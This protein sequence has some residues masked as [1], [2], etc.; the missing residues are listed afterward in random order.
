M[1]RR[2]FLTRKKNTNGQQVLKYGICPVCKREDILTTH[3]IKKRAVFGENEYVGIICR[4]CHDD[5]DRLVKVFENQILTRFEYCYKQIWV[6]YTRQGSISHRK[7]KALAKNQFLKINSKVFYGKKSRDYRKKEV[8]CNGSSK[9]KL[10]EFTNEQLAKYRSSKCPVCF[11]STKLTIHHIKKRSVFGHNNDVGFPC[12]DC[13]D[14]I[15]ES[16]KYLEAEI[17]KKFEPCYEKI[18]QLYCQNGYISED[19]VRKMAKKQLLKVK[20]NLTGNDK[21]H[22]R[23]FNK[24]KINEAEYIL[25]NFQQEKTSVFI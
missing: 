1:S 3:H 18:W 24:R 12:R 4:K 8:I 5:I 16:V 25:T 19:R 22:E 13:H 14:A 11:Q 7:L 9:K 17:L 2:C 15:E 6:F 21:K 20:D 10:R 23:V